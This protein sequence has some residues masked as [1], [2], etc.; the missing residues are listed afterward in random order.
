MTPEDFVAVFIEGWTKAQ[1]DGFID[2]FRPLSHGE[3]VASQPLLPTAI[4]PDAYMR[5]FRNTFALL[6]NV[7]IEV[8][9]SAWAG[10]T[11]FI[12]SK[13]RA[14]LGGRALTLEVCDRFVLRDGLIYRRHAYFDPTPIVIGLLLRPWMLRTAVRGLRG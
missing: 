6:R 11:V 4:G 7:R 8:L 3:V 5:S 9:D 2:H 12:E 14:T 1:P 13:L 10:D